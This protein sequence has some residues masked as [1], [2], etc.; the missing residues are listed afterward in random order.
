MEDLVGSWWDRLVRRAAYPGYPQAAT[1][2]ELAWR[3]GQALYLPERIDLYP[4]AALNRGLYFWLMALAAQPPAQGDWLQSN[5]EGTA[6]CL[7]TMPGLATLYQRLVAALLPLRNWP[8]NGTGQAA[9]QA[10]RHALLQPGTATALPAGSPPPQPVPLWLHPS[11]PS[12]AAANQDDGQQPE[13]GAG[14]AKPG[15]ATVPAAITRTIARTACCCSF[16]PKASLPGT[17]TCASTVTRTRTSLTTV[18]PPKTWIA[19]PS[20]ATARPAPAG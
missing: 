8:A 2:V 20:A 17:T 1:H 3:D 15:A 10:I 4:D 18:P 14:T 16:A 7:T 5:S 19:S 11:P 9:E 12:A 13:Q 6:R